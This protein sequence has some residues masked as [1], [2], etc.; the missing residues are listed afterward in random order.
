M[1]LGPVTREVLVRALSAQRGPASVAQQLYEETPESL[2]AQAA[3]REQQRLG[4]E[5]ALGIAQGRPT[6]RARRELDNARRG[7]WNQRWSA[8]MDQAGGE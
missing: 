2:V 5:P 6:K 7:G 1:R 4:A 8:S 3:A